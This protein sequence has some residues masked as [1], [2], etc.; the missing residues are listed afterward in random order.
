MQLVFSELA[1]R[2]IN[3]KGSDFH[4]IEIIANQRDFV[5]AQAAKVEKIASSDSSRIHEEPKRLLIRM[6]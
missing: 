4:E 2:H 3:S 5:A 6:I 1:V